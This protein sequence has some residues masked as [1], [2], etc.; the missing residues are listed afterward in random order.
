M[1]PFSGLTG[2]D[3]YTIQHQV[4]PDLSSVESWCIVNQLTINAKKTQYVIF[5]T[6]RQ[7][8]KYSGIK[9]RIEEHNLSE[10]DDYKYLGTI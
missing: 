7:K 6:G 8:D 1:N 4:Q 10:V 5:S 2:T 3:R 9:L